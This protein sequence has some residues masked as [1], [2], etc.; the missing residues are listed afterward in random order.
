[1]MAG[2]VQEET[3]EWKD[4]KWVTFTPQMAKD[5]LAN[6]KGNRSLRKGKMEQ[7]ARL[8]E[9][10]DW[11]DRHPQSISFDKNG[12]LIDGQ[13]RLTAQIQADK[14]ITYLVVEEQDPEVQVSIDSGI[15][16]N[17]RDALHFAGE[18][19]SQLMAAVARLVHLYKI[20]ALGGARYSNVSNQEI[21]RTVRENPSIRRSTELAQ[22]AKGGMTP[23]APSVLGAAHWIIRQSNTSALADAFIYRVASLTGEPEGSPILALAR[24]ANEIK[25]ARQRVHAR[26]LLNLVIKAWNYDVEGKTTSKLSLYTRSGEYRHPVALSKEDYGL[27]DQD[28]DD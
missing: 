14:T 22:Q 3:Q 25:R 15:I 21:L 4:P 24:R 28:E 1:M 27:G 19:N 9:S 13:H 26:D 6:N 11:V 20:G 18:E 12:N 2:E 10:G 5:A 16:R 8:M 7:Y 17:P 23:I